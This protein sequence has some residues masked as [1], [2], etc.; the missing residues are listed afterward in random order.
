MEECEYINQ[1]NEKW[2]KIWPHPSLPKEPKYPF[3]KIPIHKYLEKYAEIEP[4]R[5]YLIY[6]GRKISYGEIDNLS[7]RFANYLTSTGFAR[8]RVA[9]LLPNIPQFYIA[10][11]GTLKVGGVCALLNPMLKEIELE[12]F[13]QLSKPKVLLV[14]ES[15]YQMVGRIVKKLSRECTIIATSIDKFIP[16]KPD[17]PLHP[18][19]KV[20]LQ[21]QEGAIYLSDVLQNSQSKKSNIEV[22]IDDYATMNFTG[23]TTGLPKCVLHKHLN[24]IYTGACVHTFGYADILVEHY[25][26][27]QIDFNNFILKM[28]NEEVVLAAMPIFWVAGNDI[29][30]VGPTIS[31]TTIVLL[32]RWDLTAAVKAIQRYSIKTVYAPFDLYWEIINYQDV[33]KYD[34]TSLVSCTGSSFVKSLTQEL[35]DKWKKL[36]GALLHEAA[37][38]L[39][40]THTFDTF[41]S[42]FH[43]ED[44]D[45]K[46]SEKYGGIFCGI[47]TPGTIIKI[48]DG[49][50]RIVPFGER[51]EIAIKSPS[52]VEGYLENL[53]ETKKSFVNGWLLTGDIG[54]YD[55][56]GF[57]YYI[58]RKKY[59]LKVSGVSVYPSEIEFIL[60]KHPSVEKAGV[61]G[62]SDPKKGEVP[63]AFAKLKEEFQGKVKEEDLLEW[64]REHMAPYNIPKKI[65]IRDSLP[66]TTTGK[67]IREEL[68]KIFK[69]L[70]KS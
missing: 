70:Y 7:D 13:L 48:V 12:Q 52:L 38:G 67:V 41:V 21:R 16:H 60:L 44:M 58:S 49:R 56:N 18:H 8:D 42:G 63:I 55:G 50:G 20:R 2:T 35:R 28:K 65:L 59:M 39:T 1:L 15:N 43:K 4:S 45:I 24:I 40:E 22:K 10:Y 5:T 31:G 17:I 27:K 68:T 47:P 30:V 46:E 23:G 53:E 6:Y 62:T 36:T 14:L 9:L 37:Y 34:L 11:F 25:G 54:M 26:G 3:G 64:C 33:C 51:G 32:V 69:N 61:I 29:G 66:L 57:F 19:M